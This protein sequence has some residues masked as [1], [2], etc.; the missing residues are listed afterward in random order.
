MVLSNFRVPFGECE[1]SDRCEP[2]LGVRPVDPFLVPPGLLLGD[3]DLDFDF[4]FPEDLPFGVPPGDLLPLPLVPDL[5]GAGGPER[6]LPLGL[7][8]TVQFQ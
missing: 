1:L 3:L 6:P 5:A 8:L 4:V 2:D 7:S